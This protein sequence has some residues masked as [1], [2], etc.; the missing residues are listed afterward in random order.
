M[1]EAKRLDVYLCEIEKDLTRNK[2]TELIKNRKVK[3]EGEV[4]SKPSFKISEGQSVEIELEDLYVSR[5]AKKLKNHLINNPLSI[6]N[7]EC[8]DIGSS[9][10]GFTQVLLEFGAKSVTCIDTGKEQLHKSIREKSN[11]EVHEETDIRDFK[12]NKK[13]DIVTCDV[14]FISV[15]KILEDIDRLSK[16]DLILLFKPQFEVG[17]GVKRNKKGVVT[18]SVAIKNAREAFTK[19]CEEYGWTLV[20]VEESSVVGKEGNIEFVY[21]FFKS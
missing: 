12:P 21:K 5:A 6:E 18:D 1:I 7:C 13:Y 10:G 20:C 9:T 19:K 17:L 8:L 11:V 14:S 2:A 15:I 3:V 4:V 16:R